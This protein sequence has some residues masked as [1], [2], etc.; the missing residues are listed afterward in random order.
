MEEVVEA[1]AH[2]RSLE[3]AARR[4]LLPQRRE[5]LDLYPLSVGQSVADEHP[6][7]LTTACWAGF[8]VFL[9]LTL[10]WRFGGANFPQL[11]KN[12]A[13]SRLIYITQPILSTQEA[14]GAAKQGKDSQRGYTLNYGGQWSYLRPVQDG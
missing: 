2:S 13:C 10:L 1:Q 3:N 14:S 9:R 4:F 11:Q 7:L 8:V 5:G 12:P 6:S